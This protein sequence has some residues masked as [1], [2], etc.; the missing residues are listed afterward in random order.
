MAKDFSLCYRNIRDRF[1]GHVRTCSHGGRL[2]GWPIPKIA[3]HLVAGIC[4]PSS[5]L[6]RARNPRVSISPECCTVPRVACRFPGNP[7]F[8][9][10]PPTSARNLTSPLSRPPEPSF[11]R[12]LEW[13]QRI[14]AN[15]AQIATSSTPPAWFRIS[16]GIDIDFV[17]IFPNACL[18]KH[19][20]WLSELTSRCREGRFLIQGIP[21][22]FQHT[23]TTRPPLRQA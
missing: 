17:S 20:V 2:K 19:G 14:R 3:A 23:A 4:D 16:G 12:R 18:E 13:K 22:G 6:Y 21:R 1:S 8:Q 10:A 7:L 5:A 9:K 15:L 11:P